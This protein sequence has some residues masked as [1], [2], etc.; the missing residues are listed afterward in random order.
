MPITPA[1]KSWRDT[2]P[3]HPACELFPPISADELRT[4]GEDIRAKG[5]QNRIALWAADPNSKK[6][7]LDGRN[8]LDAMELV[9]L[10]PCS[11]SQVTLYGNQGVDPH[12]YVISANIHRRHLTGEQKRELIAK[13]LKAT[14]EKSDRQ[15]SETVKADHK[16]VA[17]VRAEK[18]STGEIPQLTKTVGK[19][20]KTRKQ[21]A[22]KTAAP[23]KAEER[24]SKTAETKAPAAQQ[25]QAKAQQDADSN[26]AGESARKD[27]EIND[28]RS[29][30]RRLEIENTGLRSEINELRATNNIADRVA[31]ALTLDQCIERFVILVQDEPLRAVQQA[32][33]KLVRQFDRVWK[34]RRKQGIPTRALAEQEQTLAETAGALSRALSRPT[35]RKSS[36][37]AVTPPPDDGLDIPECLRRTAP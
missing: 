34:E 8:R 27:S 12:T 14:P 35:P 15:I 11:C 25:T 22:K 17:S 2:F 5:L 9:G 33:N 7:L 36:K 29:A 32:A 16:T 26:S 23:S 13:L 28:L 3:I 31:T 1:S 19:D 37:R 21:P 24:V 18:I 30:K 6:F 20:G 10:D 4:L